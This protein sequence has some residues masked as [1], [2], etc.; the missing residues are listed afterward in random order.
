M[1]S[2]KNESM[3]T[4]GGGC[5]VSNGKI[6][7]KESLI[8]ELCA[9]RDLGFVKSIRQ[10]KTKS[11][12]AVGDTLEHLLGID[13]NNLPLPNAGEWELKSQA[14]SEKGRRAGSL[15]T[16]LHKEPSP[17]GLK[18]VSKMLLP[19]YGW[20]HPE[21][22]V[23]YPEDELSLRVTIGANTKSGRGFY[24][25][26][27]EETIGEEQLAIR[28]DRKAA[29]ESNPEWLAMVENRGGGVLD[30]YPYWGLHDLYIAFGGKLKNCFYAKAIKKV[31]EGELHFHYL[32][33][34]KLS[35]LSQRKVSEALRAGQIYVDIDARTGH[36]HGTKFRAN[37]DTFMSFYE[38]IEAF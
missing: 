13:T 33:F 7:T 1:S 36:N 2:L 16:L 9:I 17:T 18:M 35:G 22:G 31:I 11:D 25:E 10:L 23:K 6:F 34:Y 24:L 4:T 28:F 3:A 15:T 29:L 26:F 21:A 5:S 27:S 8:S 20:R 19:V 14:V 30:P 37:P 38:N 12:A 32:E